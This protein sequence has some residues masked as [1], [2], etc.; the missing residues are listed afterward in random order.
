MSLSRSLWFFS[1]FA[2]SFFFLFALCRVFPL[3]IYSLSLF[4]SFSLSLSIY[5]SPVLYVS[6]YISVCLPCLS[7]AHPENSSSEECSFHPPGLF[8][9]YSWKRFLL[10]PQSWVCL[11]TLPSKRP[12]CLSIS[13]SSWRVSFIFHCDHDLIMIIIIIMRGGWVTFGV[14]SHAPCSGGRPLARIVFRGLR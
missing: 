3:Y 8:G 7:L 11:G 12:M 1:L 14:A 2:V 5:L 4:V 9:S 13:A 6:V 10:A